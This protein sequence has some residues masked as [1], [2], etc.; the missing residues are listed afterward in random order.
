LA[1]KKDEPMNVKMANQTGDLGDPLLIV[2]LAGITVALLLITGL[3]W[4]LRSRRRQSKSAG[5]QL[6]KPNRR[7]PGPEDSPETSVRRSLPVQK[8]LD[9]SCVMAAEDFVFSVDYWFGS[10]LAMDRAFPPA[11]QRAGCVDSHADTY[12]EAKE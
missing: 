7:A 2:I 6:L 8:N 11:L 12:Y 4:L 10:R 1:Y 9:Q 3:V 5:E